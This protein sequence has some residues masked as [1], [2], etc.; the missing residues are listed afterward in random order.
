MTQLVQEIVDLTF[1]VVRLEQEKAALL[2]Q[3]AE[4]TKSES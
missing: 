1:K 2:K 3:L 4:V